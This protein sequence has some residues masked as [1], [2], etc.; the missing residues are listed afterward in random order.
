M[1]GKQLTLKELQQESLKILKDVHRFCIDNDILY[2]VAYGTL[3]GVI[4]HHGFIPWDDDID[5]IMPRP[6]YDRFIRLYQSA[7]Y[8]LKSPEIDEDDMLAFARVYDSSRTCIDSIIPWCKSDVGVWIDV[9]PVDCVPDEEDIF[10]CR[11]A[12]MQGYWK[13]SITA[14]TAC[15]RFRS[16]KSMLFNIKLIAKK[17]LYGNGKV[18]LRC[19][20]R[21]VTMAKEFPWGKTGHFSQ[22]CCLDSYEYHSCDSFK[23]ASYMPFEDTEVMVMNGYDEVL[24]ACFGDYMKLP[25]VEQQVGHTNE[26]IKFYWKEP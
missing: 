26:L 22:L 11:Y 7:K 3:I 17:I 21:V 25:P 1:K 12:D 20:N 15:G 16:D 9:F 23:S 24:R 10:R 2:S 5:I 8:K 4:R 13:K 14:R 18:A 6:H 19:I